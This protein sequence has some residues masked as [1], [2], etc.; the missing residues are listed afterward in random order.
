MT[1]LLDGDTKLTTL[2]LYSPPE[3][4]REKFFALV[5]I[6]KLAMLTIIAIITVTITLKVAVELL[7]MIRTHVPILS[8]A[9]KTLL[10]VTLRSSRWK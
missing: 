4:E 8:R 2:S 7:V 5:I 9:I 10:F 1:R 6:N 3:E